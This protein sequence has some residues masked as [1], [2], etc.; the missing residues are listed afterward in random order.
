MA[1]DFNILGI[2]LY[3]IMI[4][5]GLLVAIVLFRILCDKKKLPAN[6]FNFFIIVVVGA[7]L[8]GFLS[9]TL[10]QSFY[11]FLESGVWIWSGMTFLGGLI[12][13]VVCFLL[14]YFLIGHFLFKNKE[15]IVWLDKFVCCA[16]PCIVVAHAFGRFGCLCAGC[17]Y[18]IRSES[19]GLPMLIDGVWEKRVPTQLLE[20][21]FLLLLFGVLLYLLLKK[22]NRF[23]PSVYLVAYGVW[24]FAIEYLRDDPRG[25]SG[26]SFLTP[27]QLSSVLL[28]V[29][30]VALI[31]FYLYCYPKLIAKLTKRAEEA[32]ENHDAQE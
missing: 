31:F 29:L 23:L 13:G 10:F 16:V 20:A 7:I 30:G 12:G 6:V 15:H 11:N 24:R 32:Q 1:P 3:T 17:C 28:V 14:F 4:C 22:N 18:G 21:I 5:I 19:F 9:A 27:S 8:L 26:I 2:D 25:D